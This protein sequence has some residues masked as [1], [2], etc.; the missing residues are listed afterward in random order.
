MSVMLFS[1]PK[2]Y[3]R[4]INTY[5][6]FKEQLQGYVWQTYYLDELEK[7]AYGLYL[8]NAKSFSE[9]Y[10]EEVIVLDFDTF[11]KEIQPD[12]LTNRYPNIYHFL[13]S[14]QCLRYNIEI[15]IKKEDNISI[16]NGIKFLDDLIRGLTE[17]II[18]SHS[19]Y[20]QARYGI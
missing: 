18:R 1:D 20:E 7:F 9:R 11:R 16:I 12:F 13:K 6:G 14:L 19:E 5:S 15:D 3:A 17:I 4:I 2:G 8:A 10:Q